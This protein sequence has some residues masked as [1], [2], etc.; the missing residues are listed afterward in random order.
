MRC[1][2]FTV[3]GRI[4]KYLVAGWRRYAWLESMPLDQSDRPLRDLRISVTDR[5]NFRCRYCMPAE[6]FGPGYRFLQR[7]DLLTY[8]E[9]EHLAALVAGLGVRKFRLTG[10]E[11][12]LR[13]GLEELVRMLSN[14]EGVEDLAMT[15]NGVLLESH[16]AKLRRAGL[17]RVTVS[18]DA[19]DKEVFG[20][21][22]GVG[23][24]VERVLNG[25][26]RARSEGLG[27][28]IN[29][30]V[31]RGIN[32][33]EIL[34]LVRWGSERDIPVRF[35][36]YMDVGETNGWRMEQVVPSAEVFEMIAAEF[37]LRKL[38][39]AHRGEVARRH[40][41]GKTKGEVGFISSVTEPF[42][43]DCNRLRLSA[44]GKLYTCLFAESG[45]D[46]REL[47]RAGREKSLLLAIQGVWADRSDR[48]SER[49]GAEK[50]QK[51]EMSY[52]GG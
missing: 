14:L 5:C 29:T 18:L 17:H 12:L 9:I 20:Q 34:P 39:P 21:M 23:A 13:Q 4:P 40:Q 36:E 26:E 43:G 7:K 42:C 32:E 46:V 35:I 37:P 48:Y 22:N 52:I 50:N 8:E 1:R 6:V 30:V 44:E 41:I 16:A 47:M 51:V 24:K 27:V 31:Q 11:P 38:E 15:T 49:R 33:S 45:F 3:N 19:L 28:K 10:G 2:Q 25:I